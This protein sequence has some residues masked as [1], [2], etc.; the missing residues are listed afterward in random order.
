MAKKALPCPTVARLLLDYIPETGELIWRSRPLSF[1]NATTARAAHHAC[2]QWN[3]RFAGRRAF[4]AISGR[5]RDKFGGIM[6]G[7][8][9][10][11]HRVIWAIQT[12]AWPDD[13]ID[14]INGVGTDN[15]W[16]NLREASRVENCRNRKS[17]AG[18][19]SSYLG[20]NRE[21]NGRFRAQIMPRKGVIQYLG[22][23]DDE[24]EAAKAYDAAAK[25]NHGEYARLNFP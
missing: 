17:R 22:L 4:T 25:A 12:G 13:E 7:H 3:S 24:I 19:T 21:P 6:L 18:S 20:V 1:F 8:S 10:Q 14:H 5:E 15:R 2:A 16:R 11:A 23:F 9:V